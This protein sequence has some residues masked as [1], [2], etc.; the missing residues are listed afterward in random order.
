MRTMV[1]Y[2]SVKD[3]PQEGL[4]IR[5][6]TKPLDAAEA[7]DK[8]DADD[9]AVLHVSKLLVTGWRSSTKPEEVKYKFVGEFSQVEVL[10]AVYRCGPKLS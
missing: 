1:F 9:N 6:S 4:I 8:F 10:Q 3:M 5:G 2:S 7:I